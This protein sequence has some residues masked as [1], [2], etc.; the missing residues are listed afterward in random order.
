VLK[1][2]G[3]KRDGVKGGWRKLH[4][5]AKHNYNIFYFLL[6]IRMRYFLEVNVLG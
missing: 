4:N 6:A 5:L 3:L 1:I 2:F